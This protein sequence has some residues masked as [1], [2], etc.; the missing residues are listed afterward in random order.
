MGRGR[1]GGEGGVAVEGEAERGAEDDAALGE[2]R[3]AE[4]GVAGMAVR[5]AASLLAAHRAVP[6]VLPALLE[7]FL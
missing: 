1:R 3:R 4:A 7:L 5:V 6:A 2:H